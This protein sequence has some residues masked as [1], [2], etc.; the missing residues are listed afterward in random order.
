MK[1]HA[2]EYRVLGQRDPMIYG[3]FIE[4]F[5][6]KFTVAYMIRVIRSQMRTDCV[7]MC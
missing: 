7:Q 3:H 4:H 5:T 2:K 1:I 6:G